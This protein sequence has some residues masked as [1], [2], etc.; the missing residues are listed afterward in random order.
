MSS[1]IGSVHRAP[2]RASS[3]PPSTRFCTWRHCCRLPCTCR[4]RTL[5]WSG[6][7]WLTELLREAG[8]PI[9]DAHRPETVALRVVRGTAV[10]A[11][12]AAD[13]TADRAHLPIAF[14]AGGAVI[15]PLVV[16]GRTPA[17]P[18]A[19]RRRRR[20]TPRGRACRRS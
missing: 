4:R 15:G 8:F 11:Q 1:H 3:W 14:D 17:W 10:S 5:R 20:P 7:L 12:F 19:T 18:A 13:L 2:R 6:A 16:P 9:S